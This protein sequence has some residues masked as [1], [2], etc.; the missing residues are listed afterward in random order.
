MQGPWDGVIQLDVASI[1]FRDTLL[2]LSTHTRQALRAELAATRR[3]TAGDWRLDAG[4]GYLLRTENT[5]HS[6]VAA[7]PSYAFA[8]SRWLH[9][10]SLTLGGGWAPERATGQPWLDGW[11]VRLDAAC[12]PAMISRLDA[13]VPALPWLVGTSVAIALERR[14]ADWTLSLGYQRRGL[15][16]AAYDETFQ[17]PFLSVR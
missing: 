12:Q 13:G 14:V 9:G 6:A 8:A 1:A 11:R 15:N 17:G 16:G 5:L 2:P 4:L 10:P 3:F 7:D